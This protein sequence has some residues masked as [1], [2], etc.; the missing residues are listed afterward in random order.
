M[1]FTINGNPWYIT[2]TVTNV[3]GAGALQQLQ[4]KG[5]KTGWID[6]VH[7]W[8]AVWV[9][10]GYSDMPGQVLSFKAVLSDG[11]T[12]ESDNAAPGNW[13]FGQTFEGKNA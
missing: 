8:G 11:T 4:I 3:S 13:Q 9:L 12:V 7:S 6:M 10:T 2:V 1:K 5:T